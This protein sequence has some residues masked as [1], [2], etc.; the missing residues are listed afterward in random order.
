MGPHRH[1]VTNIHF[2]KHECECV[3][4]VLLLEG[5]TSPLCYRLP[6]QFFPM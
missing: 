6:V 5:D 2:Y 4:V 1:A 3:T